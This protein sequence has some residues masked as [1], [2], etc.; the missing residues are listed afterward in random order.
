MSLGPNEFSAAL[1]MSTGPN[2][3]YIYQAALTNNG[4][5]YA[6]IGDNA[7]WTTDPVISEIITGSGP[8][9]LSPVCFRVVVY[10]TTNPSSGNVGCT[11]LTG[12]GS[13]SLFVVASDNNPFD[14]ANF[15]VIQKFTITKEVAMW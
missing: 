13:Y 9:G 10:V 1:R 7:V 6:I 15:G 12:S 5:I 11:S 3:F 14:T 8:G 2:Y 4:L